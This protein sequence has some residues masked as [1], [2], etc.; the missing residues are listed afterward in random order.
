MLGP[1]RDP[2]SVEPEPPAEPMPDRCVPEEAP[3]CPGYPPVAAAGRPAVPP[4]YAK[5]LSAAA[6]LLFLFGCA[7][8]SAITWTVTSTL[9]EARA[10]KQRAA[11]AG[12]QTASV[13]VQVPSFEV[14]M[15]AL[16]AQNAR[17]AEPGPVAMASPFLSPFASTTASTL[18]LL[19]G[20]SHQADVLWRRAE[21]LAKLGVA[22]TLARA[23]VAP[24]AIG[25]RD[26]LG[27]ILRPDR[28]GDGLY[29][30]PNGGMTTAAMLGLRRGDLVTAIDGY[31]VLNPDSALRA[32][33]SLLRE[34]SKSSIVELVR[35]G[36]RVALRIDLPS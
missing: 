13:P 19:G 2:A 27:E 5:A 21:S 26:W 14:V 6:T 32:Y 1:Y 3:R 36:R 33:A 28:Y 11:N 12:P 29:V 10:A 16:A 7:C 34:R 15:Q 9:T 4:A 35:E 8:I 31:S 18:A 25:S 22:I 17:H 23:T 24:E 20:E 30:W